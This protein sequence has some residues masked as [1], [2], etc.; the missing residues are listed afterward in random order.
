MKKYVC[1]LSTNDY[2]DGVLIL[3]ENLKAIYSKYELL[4]LVNE[5]ITKHTRQLLEYF[6]IE[7]KDINNIAFGNNEKRNWD[8]Y[9]K[10]TFDKLNVFNLCEYEKIVYLDSDFLILENIDN[11]FDEETLSMPLDLPF[12]TNRF[13][14]GVMVIKPN[15]EDFLN[16][17]KLA[18]SSDQ[19]QREI[20]DQDIINEYFENIYPLP[21]GYNMVRIVDNYFRKCVHLDAITNRLNTTYSTDVCLKD[22]KNPKIIHYIG[23]NKP[24]KIK[25]NFDD[26]Y[27]YL[28]LYYLNKVE[29]KKLE[30]EKQNK[31]I[32]IIVPI[33][34]KEK[35][36]KRTLDSILNQTYKN[37]EII[38]IN[39]ASTDNSLQICENYK[40]KDKRIIVYN[41]T[42]NG[43]VSAARNTGLEIAKGEY[44]GFVDADDY[45]KENMYEVLIDNIMKYDVDFV[46][47]G[48]KYNEKTR[49]FIDTKIL[50][51]EGKQ[52]IINLYLRNL[53]F[54]GTVWSKLYKSKLLK[55]IRFDTKYSNNE[56]AIFEYEVMKKS[57]KILFINDILYIYSYKKEDSLTG[58]YDIKRDEGLLVLLD[59]VEKYVSLHYPYL[60]DA[61]IRKYSNTYYYILNEIASMNL[62]LYKQNSDIKKN[63]VLYNL[64]IDIRDF[65]NK[66]KTIIDKYCFDG[67]KV[68][69]RELKIRETDERNNS[70]ENI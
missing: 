40:K 30:F 10:N 35:Y 7:Y 9:W 65:A 63:K 27:Q 70:D 66:N 37:L 15:H 60:I 47:C 56:D 23:P 34:N 69:L 3:K 62:D 6:E 67:I 53:L 55:N 22:I 61:V 36:L 1:V 54:S 41:K 11:L 20:S 13:N 42:K 51:G 38:L 18:D 5:K 31:L 52:E 24:F 21:F 49:T 16:M 64:C 12:H 44:I 58:K 14:S 45:I 17:K 29:Q 50:L 2:L 32:S 28:Y 8:H 26:K 25:D 33:Y 59:K 48:I 57:Q 68:L 19:R 39:D 43:G 46:Q 4:C